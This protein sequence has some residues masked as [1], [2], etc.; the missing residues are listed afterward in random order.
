MF[1]RSTKLCSASKSSSTSTVSP[2]STTIGELNS[3]LMPLLPADG[4]TMDGLDVP[5]STSPL[6]KVTLDWS[7]S[8]ISRMLWY[9]PIGTSSSPRNA[10]TPFRRSMRSKASLGVASTIQPSASASFSSMSSAA[11]SSLVAGALASTRTMNMLMDST[12]SS[13]KGA[14]VS[15]TAMRPSPGPSALSEHRTRAP[16]AIA[17]AHKSLNLIF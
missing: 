8:R 15:R 11:S 14:S 4:H 13:G 5:V 3:T 6:F 9:A 2:S 1:P 12:S 17:P 16:M 10:V 7:V